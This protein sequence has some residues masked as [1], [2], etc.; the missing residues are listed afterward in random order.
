MKKK[1]IY[2]FG[3]PIVSLDVHAV[4]LMPF[5]QNTFL[6][7]QFIH[8]DP[9]EEIDT[10]QVKEFRGIDV[11]IGIKK[12]M[13][14]HTL[15]DFTPSPRFSPHDYDVLSQLKLLKK[16]GKIDKCIIIGIPTRGSKK[17]IQHDLKNVL[18]SMTL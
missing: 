6:D 11:V 9:T 15:D 4:S 1:I 7:Y 17:I 12:V 2:L 10:R 13:V 8:L 18:S 5:L 3:N 16:L 14:F